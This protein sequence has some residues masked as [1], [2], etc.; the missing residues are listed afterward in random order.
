[1]APKTREYRPHRSLFV[2]ATGCL[3]A[4]PSTSWAQQPAPPPADP[5]PRE[6]APEPPDAPEVGEPSQPP[7]EASPPEAPPEGAPPGAGTEEQPPPDTASPAPEANAS[8]ATE[9]QPE[10]AASTAAP[11]EQADA[12]PTQE[13]ADAQ[14]DALFGY[15]K[16]FVLQSADGAYK[17]QIGGMMQGRFTYT[18]I[19]DDDDAFNA[20][21]RRVRLAL[22][23]NVYSKDLTYKVQFSFD[24]GKP[25]V[26]DVLFDYA[27][28][29]SWLHVRVGQFKRP[30]GR[31][32]IT[33][34]SKFLLSERSMTTKAFSLDRDLGLMVHNNYTKSPTFEYAIGAFNGTTASL[35]TRGDVEVDPATGEGTLTSFR[36]SHAPT[37]MQPAL[38]A[39]LGYNFG[40]VNGYDEEDRDGGPPRF[41]VAGAAALHFDEDLDDQ[42]QVRMTAD[43][44]F[45]AY[46]L[47]A[48]VAGFW[49][50]N[51]Q[52]EGFADQD[53]E[54]AGFHGQL[55]YLIADT[56][57]P[58]F[59][60]AHVG[61]EG[62]KDRH[63]IGGG[64]GILVFG[65]H[66][67]WSNEV[68]GLVYEDDPEGT[69]NYEYLSQV[70][71]TF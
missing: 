60:Y 50:F 45:K 34:A 40:K 23:G 7:A 24:R 9:P 65:G 38:V 8:A 32:L 27:F 39:R 49:M 64:V 54:S 18:A 62:P 12:A 43:A 16:G 47:A 66:I 33:S 6:A 21:L 3:L 14:R 56:V 53:L 26:K 4:W 67:K 5:P 28:V 44:I 41:G 59:R 36:Q 55:G 13:E 17:L 2:I 69:T 58:A 22:K 71:G 48:T 31:Q 11:V 10:T 19:Q 20:Q 70:Q 61:V 42:S 63:E 15:D 51:Q 52:G 25:E 30:V 46:G 1:M 68:W 57:E 37:R 29:K 35:V